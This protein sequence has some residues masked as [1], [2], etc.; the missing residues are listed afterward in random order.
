M[1]EE[2]PMEMETEGELS[3]DK[4]A[5]AQSVDISGVEGNYTFSVNLKS[6]DLGCDQYADWWE[7]ISLDKKLVYRRILRHSHVSEQPFIRSGGPVN[8]VE[9]EVVYIR[10]HINNLSYGAIVLKGDVANG[11]VKDTLAADFA[12][13]LETAEPLPTNCAF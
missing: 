2:E 10:G 12:K 8:V 13:G 7:V 11:F 9:N 6:P 4:Q 5:I 3:E 1:V